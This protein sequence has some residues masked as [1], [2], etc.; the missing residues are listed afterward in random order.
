[1]QD[2]MTKEQQHRGHC[3]A[4]K[5]ILHCSISKRLP[6]NLHQYAKTF[7]SFITIELCVCL[8]RS[9]NLTYRPSLSLLSDVSISWLLHYDNQKA[10]D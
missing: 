3:S 4:M 1:M 5:G 6:L 2:V 7:L 10:E 9:A 8:C